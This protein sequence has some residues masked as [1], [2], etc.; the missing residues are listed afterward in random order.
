MIELFVKGN[1]SPYAQI[2]NLGKLEQSYESAAWGQDVK[3]SVA[4][5]LTDYWEKEVGEIIFPSPLQV[6]VILEFRRTDQYRVE[7]V[8][9]QKNVLEALIG[10]IYTDDWQVAMCYSSVKRSIPAV[11]AGVKIKVM[12]V[13]EFKYT[14]LK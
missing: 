12:P 11:I 1:P 8:D 13:S 5:Q 6:A 9:M 14:M 3:Y 10:T 2:V 4:E 7:L